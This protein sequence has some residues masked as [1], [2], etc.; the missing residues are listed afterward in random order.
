MHHSIRIDRQDLARC[1]VD[2][3]VSSCVILATYCPEFGTEISTDM[4]QT[5][6]RIVTVGPIEVVL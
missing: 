4:S 2:K 5:V 6:S 3:N 1:A